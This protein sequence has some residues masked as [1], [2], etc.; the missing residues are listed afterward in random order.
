MLRTGFMRRDWI[1]FSQ[2]QAVVNPF[3]F[4]KIKEYA[5]HLT[6]RLQLTADCYQCQ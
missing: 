6:E 5:P 2:L 1:E 3:F 4:F